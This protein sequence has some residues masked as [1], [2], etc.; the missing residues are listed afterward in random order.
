M[1]EIERKFLLKNEDWRSE[2]KR[3]VL[4]TQ[5]YLCDEYSKTVRVR[6]AGDQAFLTIKSSS[7][8]GGLSR[9]EFEYEIPSKDANE[10]LLMCSTSL[11]K[12][13]HYVPHDEKHCW[14]IDEYL[15]LNAGLFTAEIE[16]ETVT[17]KIVMPSWVGDE[18]TGQYNYTNAYLARTP[19]QT[20]K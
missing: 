17:D 5:G 6:S 18:V 20:W 11:E 12:I 10:L 14:E 16:L 3:S 19:F 9:P 4:M 13:R 15:G 2:V 1:I 8:D 7:S